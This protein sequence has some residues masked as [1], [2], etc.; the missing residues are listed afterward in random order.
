MSTVQVQLPPKLIPVFMGEARYRGS[1][2][3]RGSG[4][5]RSFAKMTAVRGLMW[6]QAGVSGVILCGREYMNSLD[7]SSMAEVKAAIE[8]EPFLLAHYD[9]GETYIRTRDRRVEYAFAG[10]RNSLDSIKS[11]ARVL[12]LWVDE[13]EQVQEAAWIKAVP[14]IRETDSEIWVTWNPERKTSA[15]HKRF[16]ADPP[17][18]AKIVELNYRDNPWFPLVL[19]RERLDDLA[20]RPDNYAHVWDG[21]F[22]AVTVGAYYT[23]QIA[24]MKREGR[25]AKLSRDPLMSTRCYWDIG[26]TGAKAD[27]CAI[28]VCQFIGQEVRVFDYYE[29]RG[30]ELGEHVAWLRRRRYENATQILPHDGRHHEKISRVTYESALVDAGFDVDVMKNAGLGATAARIEQTRR[31]FPRVS[32]DPRCAPGLDALAAY[33]EKRDDKRELGLGPNHDWASHAAD[34]FGALCIDYEPPVASTRLVIPSIGAV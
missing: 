17:E 12:L 19:E 18:G 32:M 31:I 3:G 8:S 16:R 23:R 33:H 1:F 20:K 25:Y 27:A 26:G 11:K 2:G 7:E 29:A 34:A 30:Q 10:L 21:D 9:I 14:S 13:A 28:W 5:T 4:K 15:T 24:D 6:A 22:K